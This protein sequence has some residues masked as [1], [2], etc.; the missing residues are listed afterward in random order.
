MRAINKVNR[1]KELL[2]MLTRKQLNETGENDADEENGN[3]LG[4]L[5]TNTTL[6]FKTG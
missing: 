4:V 3:F 5:G 1:H 2:S 6:G